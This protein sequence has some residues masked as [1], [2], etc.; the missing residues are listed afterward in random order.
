MTL[1][2][3]QAAVAAK[4]PAYLALACFGMAAV[5]AQ[6]Q[7]GAEDS[8]LRL[9]RV[10][11]TDT[12]V[13]DGFKTDRV[14]SP[15]F[16]QPL[17]DTPQT[18]QIVNKD[19]FL[20]Q[21]ATT[22]TEALR[23]SPAVGTFSA[24]E[25]G[26]TSTGDEIFMRGF[27]SSNSIF[28][29]GIRDIGSYSRD[30]FNTEQVEIT[31]GPSGPDY[32]RTAPTGNINMVT[33]AAHL[34]S[35]FSGI[36][37]FGIHGQ[38]RATF[39]VN[40]PIA[41]LPNAAFRLNALW[42]DSKNPARD[43]V[44]DKRVGIAPSLGI[45][46]DTPTRAW[47]NF[48]YV[49]QD[50]TPDGFVPTIAMPGWAP[51][52]GLE[53]LAG[54]RVRPK[55][56]YGTRSDHDD[57]TTQMVT[58]KIEHDF[59]D[60]VT[61]SNIARWGSS[62]QDYLLTSF[63]G[64]SDNITASDPADLSTYMLARNVFSSKD[65][66]N[67]ILTDQLNLRAD[68]ATGGI[69]H[70]LSLG[71]EFTSEKQTTW[72]RAVGGTAADANL[73]NPDWN[74]PGPSI[75]RDGGIARGK[76]TSQS[77]YLFDTA[78]FLDNVLLV[79]GGIRLDHYKTTYFSNAVCN[80]GTGRGAVACSGAPVGTIVTTADLTSKRTL[81]NWKLGAVVKPVPQLS[82]YANYA[83]GQQPPGGALFTLSAAANSL[84]NPDM[85]PQKAKTIEIGAKWDALDG[86]LAFAG[87]LFRTKVE[88]EINNDILDDF[89]NPTQTGHKRVQGVELSVVGNITDN[90][91]L[92]AGY[93]HVDT[94]VTGSHNAADGSAD[95][96]FS[97]KDAFTSWLS[98]RAPFGVEVA[99][100]VRYT[101]GYQ[102][103]DKGATLTPEFTKGYA[104]VDMSV[105]YAVSDNLTLRAN[106]YNLL[107]KDY[108]ASLNRSGYRYRPGTPQTV[109]FTADFRF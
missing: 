82:L 54:H 35:A 4:S 78:K 75:A 56:Y 85:R 2:R 86:A 91:S 9:G 31:K 51:Q 97:P 93:T 69:E 50:N 29:D 43:H 41:A 17:L 25:N 49:K 11:V 57:V 105:G 40:Q 67:E 104:V 98:Y 87:A 32:G 72:A 60:H 21:G 10:V 81:F 106:V 16:T 45:G 63:M 100:G 58:L 59:N 79:T 1:V 18:V 103:T 109:L 46:I 74:D 107:D 92:M 34:D 62:T 73:Y 89:N 101:S 3:M 8:A 22:L 77:V 52:P 94:K 13:D 39:D 53:P 44:K 36:L 99:G 48:L 88:N 24:G 55:N 64:T 15:K 23:N 71:A 38:K 83:V 68:F 26:A 70:A 84:D 20:Q 7:E 96:T 12:V 95:L 6:A 65:V 42:Q 19:L 27:D 61:L 108:V 102:R 80:D 14:Q 28:V 33:K 5:S 66:K 90:L 30:I 37:S 76:T 47:L